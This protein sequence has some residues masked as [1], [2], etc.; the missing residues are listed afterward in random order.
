MILLLAKPK[1]V[2]LRSSTYC[3]LIRSTIRLTMMSVTASCSSFAAFLNFCDSWRVNAS[4]GV[5]N[6]MMDLLTG[7]GFDSQL[8]V[9]KESLVTVL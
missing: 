7:A 4:N 5:E 8:M 2:F 6:Y 9:S 3:S 1:Y